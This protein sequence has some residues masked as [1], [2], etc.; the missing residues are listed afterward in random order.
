MDPAARTRSSRSCAP[1]TPSRR[2]PAASARWRSANNGTIIL[3]AARA[4]SGPTTRRPAPGPRAPTTSRHP[5]GR[6]AGDRPEQRLDRLHGLRRG[7]ALRRQLLRRRHLQVH[8]RRRHLDARVGR[9]FTGVSISAIA[10]DPT[11]AEPPLRRDPPRPRRQPPHHAADR[12]TYGVWESNDGGATGRCARAPPT[13]STARPTSSWT[14]RTR[15]ILCASFW[16]DGIYRS[17]DGGSTWTSRHGRPAGR[18]LRT[19]AAPASRSASRT[20]RATAPTLYTGFD[21]TSTAT[22]PRRADLEVRPTAARWTLLPPARRRRSDAVVGLLRHA[23]LLRQRRQAR[24]DQPEHRLRARALTATTTA[25][26]PAAS[27]APPTAARPGRA[28]ATTC[29]PTST[30]SPSSR[31]TPQ[32]VADRQRRRRLAVARPGGG[33]TRPTPLDARPTGRTSTAGRPEHGRAGPLDRAC[34]H[35]VH[36]R[37]RPS[38]PCPASTGAAR[39][40]TARCASRPP[41]HAGSTK[42][43][44]TAARSSSTRRDASTYVF[45]TYFGISPVPLSTDGSAARSSATSPSTA[46]STSSDRAEF[47]VPWVENQAQHQP[48]VPRHLPALPHRQRRGADAGD[49]TWHADQPRPHQGCTGAAPNGARGCLISR[50]SASPT[51]ATASTPA[52]TRAGSRSARTRSRLRTARPGPGS[53]KAAC[54]NRPVTRFAVD[55][56]NWRDRLRRLR[57]LQRGHAEPP[58]PRLHD[59]RRRQALEGRHRQPARRPGQLDRRST[60]RYPNTI[61]V[62]TDVGPFV[63]NDGGASWQ[64]LGT[65]MPKVAVW[66]LD[67]DPRQR[68][69]RRRHPRPRRLHA[70]RTAT[71]AGARRVQGRR[72][73]A[74]RPGQHASTTRSR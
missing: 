39:R 3:G 73:H 4:A 68:R 53:A 36:L 43:A 59:H 63:T 25:R 19:G 35:P 71:A 72:R 12:R 34:D 20:R 41:T 21:W 52:P 8:R 47:Y 15:T 38:R 31:T 45:G 51:A 66:Q 22:A 18:Q 26:S 49:V 67:Y 54:P 2:C 24:P 33:R 29:T 44:V 74:G 28:S 57:R 55:R 9:L 62:G 5:V 61:Y 16:G 50:A 56:S 42:P 37:S 14:R 1:A 64:P 30:R 58:R 32:H 65:G 48:D 13:S 46:A 10:V 11:N 23:V 17:T 40:T 69:A 6:R 60:R 70:A 7:R 27:T